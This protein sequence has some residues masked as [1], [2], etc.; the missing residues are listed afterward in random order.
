[1]AVQGREELVDTEATRQDNYKIKGLPAYLVLDT[2][3]SMKPH[4]QM[5][6]DTL[7]EI[8]DTVDTSPQVS[9]FIHLSVIS[10]NTQ[11]HVVT[12]MEDLDDVQSLPTVSCGGLTNFGLMFELIRSRIEADVPAMARKGLKVL[13]PVVF[14]LT[15]GIPSDDPDWRIQLDELTDASW[16]AH[17]NIITYGF[18]AARED[19]LSRIANIAAFAAEKG[20]D[21]RTA[22]AEALTSLLN[23]LVASAK[24]KNFQVPEVVKGYRSIPLEYVDG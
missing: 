21:N 12:A 1:M 18:G 22:L 11:A 17:P 5:L 15:D 2:S 24:T 8:Y 23:S 20:S 9:E 10:F 13:R 4:E 3:G 7:M 19:V 16:K 14:L 6:N